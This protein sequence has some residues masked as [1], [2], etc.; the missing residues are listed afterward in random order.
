MKKI[1]KIL[2]GCIGCLA[3]VSVSSIGFA[4]WLVGVTQNSLDLTIAAEVDSVQNQT[5]YVDAVLVTGQTIAVAEESA[6]DRDGKKI[7]GTAQNDGNGIKVDANALSFKFQ[8]ITVRIG[9][10]VT[11]APNKVKI[12]LKDDKNTFIKVEEEEDNKM[13]VTY[14]KTES[15][16][17]LGYWTYLSFSTTIDLD[18]TNFNVSDK[19][20]YTEYTLKDPSSKAY[21]LNWGTFFGGERPTTFYN[22]LI[23]E[24]S[25]NE[26]LTMS[27]NAYSELDAMY[28][29]FYGQQL[30]LSVS[31]VNEKTS[32]EI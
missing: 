21:K 26:L 14:R 16:G 12:E 18:S 22:N 15:Q 2:A 13:G 3:V 23:A 17:G 28:K 9:D 6:V 7:V 19:E 20:T 4:T 1:N 30:T 24:Q 10:N 25:F 8:S 27:Q 11:D 32:Y 29:A 5:Q 31:L